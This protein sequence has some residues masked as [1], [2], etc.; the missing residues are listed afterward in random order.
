MEFTKE[1]I[2]ELRMILLERAKAKKIA[3][4]NEEARIARTE[5]VNEANTARN[6]VMVAL[7]PMEA[8][9]KAGISA[10]V[11]ASSIEAIK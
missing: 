1:E 4:L 2:E 3:I 8:R 7:A 11:S 5:F 10:I 9:L 6:A